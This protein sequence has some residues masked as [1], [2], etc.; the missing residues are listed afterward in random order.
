LS[1]AAIASRLGLQR[2]RDA[3]DSFHRALQSSE[4]STRPRLIREELVRLDAL[5]AR[6]R[7]R[8]EADP[9]KM[10]GRLHALDQLRQRVS[11]T[12]AA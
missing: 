1:F 9:V 11:P 12:G 4:E 6:I 2:S 3:L 10:Q 8:D 7:S 5:E